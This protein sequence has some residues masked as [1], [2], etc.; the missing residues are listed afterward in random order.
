MAA[1]KVR[2]S[3]QLLAGSVT[4]T[5]IAAAAAIAYAK[6]NLTGAIV[7]ADIV[8]IAN[9]KVTG[10]GSAALT[11][12]SAYDVAGAAAAV[13]PTTL[14]LVIGTNTQAF[15]AKLTAIA[16][17]ANAAGALTNNGSGGFSYVAPGAAAAGTLTGATLAANVLAS[18]LTS[19]GTIASGTWSASFGAVSGA[20]LTSLSAGNLTGT[21]PAGVLAGRSLADLGTRSAG[22][23]NSGN[24]P[25]AQMPSGSG[26]WAAGALSIT[27]STFTINGQVNHIGA[28]TQSAFSVIY[29]GGISGMPDY[30]TSYYIS[31]H[32]S[33]GLF[34][35][36][37][38][39]VTGQITS[40]AGITLSGSMSTGSSIDATGCIVGHAGAGGA[41]ANVFSVYWTGSTAQLWIDASNI[42]N[43]TVTSDRRIKRKIA[44]LNVGLA[45]LR[46]LR[47]SSFEWKDQTHDPG[48]HYG[49]IAQDVAK[50]LPVIAT[51]TTMPH[52]LAPDGLWRVDYEALVPILVRAVQELAAEIDT[53]KGRL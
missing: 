40:P 27:F 53:L 30:Q 52:D 2:G 51:H 39:Y 16:A 22:A 42:G 41:G 6:L 24:L 11:S 37:G 35:N 18:S 3:T 12:S 46:R 14:G 25:W 38:L 34:I 13:T 9:A 48:T 26:T 44:P 45:D 8:S 19:V 10:L 5:E 31:S 29:P 36:T 28:F 17:L 7:N 33:Y 50:V 4:N 15:N 1:T 21:V 43:I 47:P 20:N 23:L 32:A 49:L